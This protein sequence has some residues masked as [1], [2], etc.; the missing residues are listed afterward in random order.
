MSVNAKRLFFRLK[1]LRYNKIGIEF[2][3]FDSMNQFLNPVLSFIS[4]VFFSFLFLGNCSNV[5]SE[6]AYCEKKAKQYFLLCIINIK[7]AP[8][9]FGKTEWT[10]QQIQSYSQNFCV[11]DYIRKKRCADQSAF[12]P[13]RKD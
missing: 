9:Y 10:S 1:I 5:E 3:V 13:H 4:I 7:T 6:K 11:S 2:T 8:A 12:R